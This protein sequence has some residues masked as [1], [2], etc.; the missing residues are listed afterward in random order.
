MAITH[1]PMNPQGDGLERVADIFMSKGFDVRSEAIA[2]PELVSVVTSA[3]VPKH[4]REL[5][6]AVL[7]L[8]V[9]KP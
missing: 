8:E 6:R 3:T 2:S 7:H 9:T 1:I 5:F 4:I